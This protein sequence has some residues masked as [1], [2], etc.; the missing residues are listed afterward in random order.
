MH[1]ALRAPDR[2][3]VAIDHSVLEVA[4]A[5]IKSLESSCR[6]QK[7]VYWNGQVARISPRISVC[8]AQDLQVT[9]VATAV[10]G[11]LLV[12]SMRIACGSAHH[13]RSN[14][15]ESTARGTIARSKIDACLV[16]KIKS[17]GE[18]GFKP[19]LL[20]GR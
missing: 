18:G 14:F 3:S 7:W 12:P 6:I 16:K 13:F 8:P 10:A 5:A 2:R 4:R 17:G 20:R 19:P 9:V 1:R 15:G 11:K